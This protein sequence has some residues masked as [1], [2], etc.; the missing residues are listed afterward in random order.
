[1]TVD[2][3]FYVLSHGQGG[4]ISNQKF[5]AVQAG[6]KPNVVPIQSTPPA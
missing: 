2:K 4:Q 1:M 3:P 6:T 5:T